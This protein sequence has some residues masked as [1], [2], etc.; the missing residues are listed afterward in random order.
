MDGTGFFCFQTPDFKRF[1]TLL[2]VRET[3]ELRR[4][5]VVKK[6]NATLKRGVHFKLP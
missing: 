4:S 2:L 3:H 6:V 1:I 5:G